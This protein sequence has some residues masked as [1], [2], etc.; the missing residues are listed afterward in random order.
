M[1]KY[2]TEMCSLIPELKHVKT[3][4]LINAGYSSE[5]KYHIL[6]EYNNSYLL[7]L[8]S[9]KFASHKKF[10]VSSLNELVHLGVKCSKP[11]SHGYSVD[12]NCY[13]ALLTWI[14][15]KDASKALPNLSKENQFDIGFKAGKDLSLIHTLKNTNKKIDWFNLFKRKWQLNK[16]I[17]L[18]DNTR[19][20]NDSYI[21]DFIENNLLHIKNRPTNF[22]HDDFHPDNI[23]IDKG[24]YSGVIDFNRCT[25]GDPWHDFAKLFFYGSE[26]SKSFCKGSLMSYFNYSVPEQFYKVNALYT[27]V[28]MFNTLS[29][30]K[31]VSPEHLTQMQKRIASLLTDF[32]GFKRVKPVWL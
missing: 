5:Y 26:V 4:T 15:G 17:Y 2:L 8:T 30:I 6:T 13:F 18:Q 28:L 29:W 14:E 10:E 31:K 9:S 32:D 23:V 25:Y 21:F 12:Q 16:S 3:I 11:L 27:A 19:I 20:L 22:L 1:H 24:F 7:R